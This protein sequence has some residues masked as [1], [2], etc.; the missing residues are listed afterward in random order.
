[1]K[2]LVVDDSAVMRKILKD[3]LFK[4]GIT[5]VG[6]AA[7][8]REA[9]EAAMSEDYDIVLMDFNMPEMSGLDAVKEIRGGGKQVPIIMVTT[10]G[11]KSRII[12]ALKAGADNYIVKPFKPEHIAQKIRDSLQKN[13]K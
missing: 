4:A 8:G 5:D 7:D 9:V 2:G 13:S 11:E 10:E 1:M 12:D 3:A 6:E